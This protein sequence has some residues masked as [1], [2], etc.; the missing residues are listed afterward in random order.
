MARVNLTAAS[1]EKIKPPPSGQVEYYDRRLPAFGLRVSYRGS[2]SWFLMARVNGKLARL[3][4]GR[5]P[6]LSLARA[7]EKANA[8]AR[9]VAE[10]KDPRHLEADEKRKQQEARGNTF[11]ACAA[12][13]LAKHA[14][15]RLRPSTQREYLRVLTGPDTRHLHGKPIS[16]IT[17]RDMLDVID[18]ID[19][20][21][22]PG[23]AKRT[24]AY[25]RKFF[26]WCAERE[27]VSRPPTDRIP[28]PHPE[29][30]RDRVLTKDEIRDVLRALDAETSVFGPLIRVLLLTGQRRAEVAGLH[31]SELRGLN[32]A[33][34]TWDIPGARTKNGQSHLVPLTPAVLA[35][36]GKVPNL[37]D[38]LFTTTGETP[39]S[40]FGKAKAR[41]D[42]RIAEIRAKE[43]R[44]PM[45]PWTLHDLR[46]T[47][48]TMMNEHLAIPPHVVEA[49]VNH[50]SGLAKA[51]VA[52]VYNRALYMDDRRR[53]LT[54]WAKLVQAIS[55]ETTQPTPPAHSKSAI[56]PQAD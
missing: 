22:S 12:D 10:G 45:P 34:P 39:A 54:A 25:L 33:E 48:V 19:E 46:R 17:K 14:K 11:G 44:T 21:G 3:T 42:N 47:M 2:K 20:R 38:L 6:A 49:V 23:A 53:A 50:I 4:L 56:G 55:E 52:G 30:K 16:E 31:R 1:I 7:R 29:V 35:E 9:L 28:R 26:N 24:L 5:Y 41:L 32:G 36:I 51:G 13:F 15:R 43:D 40:G 18:A 37:G 8:A 27:L